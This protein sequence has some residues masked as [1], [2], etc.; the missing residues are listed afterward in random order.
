MANG[1]EADDSFSDEQQARFAA[2][3]GDLDWIPYRHTANSATALR[4]PEYRFDGV[5]IGMALH[6]IAPS[7]TPGEGLRPALQLK[8]RIARTFD[9]GPG[10]GVSYGLTWRA[11]RPSRL[12]LVPVGYA[13]GW[14][15]ALGN[16]GSVLV[17]GCRCPIVGTVCMDQFLIDITGVSGVLVGSEAVLLGRQG[18]SEITAA[19]VAA[20]LGSIPWEVLSGLQARLPRLYVRS[21]AVVDSV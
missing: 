10:E 13:D 18:D 8:A 9:L 14:R 6:G 4:R 17:S 3:I 2:L 5:R 12:A 16:R 20:L 11:G 7:N 19:E 1:D 15:R 21:G